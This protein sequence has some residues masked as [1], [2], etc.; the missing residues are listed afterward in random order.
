MTWPG[1]IAGLLASA[2]DEIRKT[3]VGR[4]GSGLRGTMD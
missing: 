1:R 3:H 4:R 2:A